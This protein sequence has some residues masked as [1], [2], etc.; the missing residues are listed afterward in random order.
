[1]NDYFPS[2]VI[3][4][5]DI[6][7]FYSQVE[8]NRL[9]ISPEVPCAVQ[10]WDG[11][12]AVNYPARE[13]G[14]SRFMKVTEAVKVCPDL[15]LL[16][17]RTIGEGGVE[18]PE[19]E[20]SAQARSK[21]KACLQRYRQSSGEII[22]LLQSL[23]HKS[24]A[25]EKGGLDEM[26]MDVTC[27]AEER[28]RTMTNGPLLRPS[29]LANDH[30]TE[31]LRIHDYANN[32]FSYPQTSGS[33]GI[34][35]NREVCKQRHNQSGMGESGHTCHH[36]SVDVSLEDAFASVEQAGLVLGGP[37][38]MDNYFDRMLVAGGLIALRLRRAITSTLNMTCSAGI[39]HNKII[40]KLG[41]SLN[42]PNKQAL[43]LPRG[44]RD[45]M[46]DVPIHKI[47][48]LGGKLGT[49][50][51]E[52]FSA[53]TAGQAQLVPLGHLQRHLGEE[54][55][56]LV[57]SRVRGQSA[58]PVVAKCVVKSI[59]CCKTFYA[60]SDLLS[61][62]KWMRIL[63]EELAQRMA[64]DEA[65][66][67][68]KARTLTLHYSGGPGYG[69]SNQQGH[70]QHGERSV[71]CPLPKHGKEGP[72]SSALTTSAMSTFVKLPNALPCVRLALCAGDFT[73]G[74]V[75]RDL[76]ITS[77][78]SAT[79]ATSSAIVQPGLA[80][81]PSSSSMQPPEELFSHV[82][83]STSTRKDTSIAIDDQ[84]STF[85]NDP[86]HAKSQLS[87]ADITSDVWTIGSSIMVEGLS[88]DG[89][90]K[91]ASSCANSCSSH[92]H[93]AQASHSPTAVKE[94]GTS[95]PRETVEAG[96]EALTEKKASGNLP[97]VNNVL[98]QVD[99][100]K[101]V[102]VAE[103]KQIM[104]EIELRSLLTSKRRRV[105]D[106]KQCSIKEAFLKK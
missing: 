18:I 44:I 95:H 35:E 48:G 43:I 24:C 89:L 39:G 101:G 76:A 75:Q 52:Y 61:I 38:Q 71:R 15:K 68:R 72:S 47:W 96:D 10:Q 51:E 86:S 79:S 78:F 105:V 106:K 1:M 69:K 46:K 73:D 14:V 28:V 85:C 99:D 7:C 82:A 55:A 90:V 102:D 81:P 67:R 40:A 12:I 9:G 21:G 87:S 42:K 45:M 88:H 100:F 64:E 26:F 8:Q 59:N 104:R 16:H 74:P 37:L 27:M 97:H 30:I 62:E 83:T 32:K 13:R 63:A 20:T 4:H 29:A 77:Y 31:P 41:S 53:T 93:C 3:I 56:A 65:D 103:Q 34:R 60:T 6:D 23:I 33:I 17:V 49:A 70:T 80:H 66:H 19:T 57:Y 58:D 98:Y 22:R 91:R 2:R 84:F 11:L 94:K 5:V 36:E 50:L 92:Q 54:K 25:F